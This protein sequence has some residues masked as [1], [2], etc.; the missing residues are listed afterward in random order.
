MGYLTKYGTIWGEI[1]ST[2]GRVFWV[3]PAAT[4]VVDGRTYTASDDQDGLSPERAKRTINNVLDNHVTANAGDVIVLL[5]GTHQ[6]QDSDGTATSLA[7]DTAGVTLM[8]LP[9]GRGNFLKPKATI[10]TVAGDQNLNAS[11]AN[12]EIAHINFTAVTTDTCIDLTADADQLHIHDCSFDMSTA[13]ADTGTIGIEALGAASNVLIDHC[14]FDCDAAQG[15]AIDA[16]ALL[17]SDIVNCLFKQNAGTWATTIL[18]GAGTVGLG[19][20]DCEFEASVGT[21]TACINGS[22]A[23]SSS[24]VTILRCFF[25]AGAATPIDNFTA[26]FAEISENYIA[27]V[28]VTGGTLVLAI[29]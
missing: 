19:I 1:P 14:F 23:D 27:D 11:A 25:A 28:G 18:C 4:Y 29:T 9:G 16:T 2:H 26:G 20:K 5:P 13:A 6:P 3:S 21:M 10:T 17:D 8:G 15:P 12:C 24:A 22:A 7:M